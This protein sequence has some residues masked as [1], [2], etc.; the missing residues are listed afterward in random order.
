M[1][2]PDYNDREHTE[3]GELIELFEKYLNSNE[4][5]FFDE[6]S[7]ERILEYYEMRNLPERAEAVADYAINQ[8]PYSSDFL[9]RKAEFLVNRKK[10]NEALDLLD[11][12]FLFDSHEIDIYLL[13]SDIFIETNQPEKAEAILFEALEIADDEEKDVVYAELSDIYEIQENFDK[14]FDCLAKALTINPS[15][16][17][18]LYK[19]SHI[20]DMTDKYD[21]SVKLHK[22]IIEKEPYAWL[23]WFNLGRAYM[24]LSLY[25]KAIE[26]FE[27]VMAIDENFD[28]VY[29]DAA[30]VYYRIENFEKAIAMFELAHEKSG[31][32]EDYSF[33]IGLCYE[34]LENY[35]SARFQFRKAARQDPFLH[36]AYFRIGETYRQEDRFE[37]ALVNYKKALKLDE[38]N[39]DYI[40]TIISIY[41]MLD[42]DTDVLE[43]LNILVNVRPDILSYWLDHIIYLFDLGKYPEA[44]EVINDAITRSGHYP[45]YFYLQSAALSYTGRMREAISVLEHALMLDYSRHTILY[46]VC[47]DV[48]MRPE[49][50]RVIGLYHAN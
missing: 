8:N 41:K 28:L 32:Y 16:E 25:E 20:V 11:K 43:Y 26:S 13:R 3:M 23:A 19:L 36:E 35:K 22:E 27:F 10:Y 21:E 38:S 39:E 37:P 46:E 34:R 44:L 6:D 18:A 42:R 5:H 2:E 31:G 33:R 47:K 45:E 24:G 9:V 15:S 12:A 4:Q 1:M 40:C 30:D 17:D 7:L 49:F 50:Q 29:R 48:A 14:A